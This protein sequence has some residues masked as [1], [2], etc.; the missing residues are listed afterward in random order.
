M[1]WDINS[2]SVNKHSCSTNMKLHPNNIQ[3]I[4]QALKKIF[5]DGAYADDVVRNLLQSNP[6]W[7]SRDRRFIASSIYSIVR[8]WKRYVFIADTTKKDSDCFE[9]VLSAYLKETYGDGLLT[10]LPVELNEEIFASRIKAATADRAVQASIPDWMDALGVK[11]LGKELWEREL[12]FS[13]LEA[14]VF[15]RV[16]TLKHTSAEIIK[17][18]NAEG[19]EATQFGPYPETLKLAERKPLQRLHSYL[20][21]G[22][23]IQDSGSQVIAHYLKPSPNAF[24]IDACA[25]A[26]GKTL[27]LS[28]LMGNKGKIVSMDIEAFKLKELERRAERAGTTIIQT[29][30]IREGV[31]T[32]LK[33]KADYLLLDVPCSGIGVLRRN[34]DDKWKLSAERIQELTQIQQQ[35]LQEY[36]SMVKPGGVLVYATCSI[37]PI[38]N[39]NQIEQ[40][41]KSNT[42]FQLEK[43]QTIYPS[44]GGDGYFMARLI[45]K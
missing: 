30:V 28:A 34:P 26:G 29:K 9:K 21:G 40:F 44:E 17:Q 8:W 36:S 20:N 5:L 7:G 22:Y 3:S 1:G 14:D 11:E 45:K 4:I 31:I 32:S 25:G 41:L 35:I 2:F 12:H 39:D 18:L 23:E 10:P 6:K 16:N 33:N 27:H 19:I 43:K 24:V 13:N 38:E 42:G 15:I 37:L